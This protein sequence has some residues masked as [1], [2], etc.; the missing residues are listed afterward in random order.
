MQPS[1]RCMN[2]TGSVDQVLFFPVRSIASEGPMTVAHS[3][4]KQLTRAL[5]T[6][7]LMEVVGPAGVCN[8]VTLP[9]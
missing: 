8:K 9:W 6:V 4:A 3:T 5:T 1:D 2:D 7:E